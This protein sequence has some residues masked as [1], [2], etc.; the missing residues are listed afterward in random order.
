MRRKSFDHLQKLSFRFYDNHKTGHLIARVTK[1]LEEIGEV[2]HPGPEDLFIAIMTFVGPSR[3]D[4]LGQ[5]AACTDNGGDRSNGCV[6]DKPLCLAIARMFLKNPTIL[7]L[8]E[9]TS[10]LDTQTEREIQQQSLAELAQGRTTLVI[11]HRLATIRNVDRIV[12]VDDMGIIERGPHDEL[13]A[14]G[15]GRKRM[16]KCERS[17]GFK[18]HMIRRAWRLRNWKIPGFQAGTSASSR[19]AEAV[20]VGRKALAPRLP[21]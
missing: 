21:A 10:A 9:A 11:A 1:D 2:A 14:R 8:D 12:V 15:G 20:Q 7:I 4:V 6:G 3:A 13:V 16:L 17:A 19:P 5:C 18:T